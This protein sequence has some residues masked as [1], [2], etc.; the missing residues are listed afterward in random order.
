VDEDSGEEFFY[1][2]ISGALTFD[3][4][5]EASGGG[6]D[7]PVMPS[8]SDVLE[9]RR[10]DLHNAIVLHGGYRQGDKVSHIDIQDDHIDTVISHIISPYPI[11]IS[12]QY[13]YGR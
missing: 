4:P 11:S 7:V 8:M 6:L 10:W 12:R 1:N 2:D 9:A 13:R 3:E 5:D